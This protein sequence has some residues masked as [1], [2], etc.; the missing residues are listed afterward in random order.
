MSDRR[1]TL[2][3]RLKSEGHV[4][5][6]EQAEK[7]G[8]TEMTIRRDLRTLEAMGVATRVHGGAIPATP[9]P[10]GLDVISKI[11]R[12]E[13]I[14]IAR[15][16]LSILSP[17]STVMMNVGTTVFQ[18]AR[19][20]AAAGIPLT[21]ITNSIP[22]AVAL[23]RS[24]CQVVI[25]GGLLRREALD[26]AG[27]LTEKNLDEHQVDILIAGCDGMNPEKGFYTGDAN[28]AAIERHSAKIARKVAIVAESAKFAERAFAKFA[29]VE[30]VSILI[31]DDGMSGAQ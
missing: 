3:D 26:L 28:L 23:H 16:T 17:G 13:Q 6:V 29:D 14:A 25:T 27:P 19:E 11:P 18:V 9:L 10:R 21:V 31:T 5:V 24:E 1:R 15:K 12:S 30:D 20:I 4:S 7:L 22:V 2:L 8:V